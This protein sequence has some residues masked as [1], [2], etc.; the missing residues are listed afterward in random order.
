MDDNTNK[1]LNLSKAVEQQE[2]YNS[3]NEP[4]S[5]NGN[6]SDTFRTPPI[7][8]AEQQNLILDYIRNHSGLSM[9]DLSKAL[10]MPSSTL[11]YK[12]RDLEFSGV[13]YSKIIVNGQN[14]TVRLL[15]S[16]KKENLSGSENGA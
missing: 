6:L 2:Q 11:Y 16:I 10:N 3:P 8:R 7:K 15:Y 4:I 5:S 13:I 12:L 1:N 9:W 14:R